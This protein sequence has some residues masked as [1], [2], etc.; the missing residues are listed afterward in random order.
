M[1]SA[2]RGGRVLEVDKSKARGVKDD[3]TDGRGSRFGW[4]I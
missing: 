4:K 1:R 3:D 2:D